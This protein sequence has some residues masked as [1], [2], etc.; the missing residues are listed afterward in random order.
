MFIQGGDFLGLANAWD[1]PCITS[2]TL[3]SS[4]QTMAACWSGCLRRWQNW[5]KKKKKK[6][7][8]MK[9]VTYPQNT[10]PFQRGTRQSSLWTASMHLVICCFFEFCQHN[11]DSKLVDACPCGGEQ[12]KT[13]NPVNK[14]GIWKEIKRENR[15]PKVLVIGLLSHYKPI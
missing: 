11:V 9:L 13:Q 3:P 15:F 6:K 1:R 2:Q 14:N 10:Q 5:Q 8:P 7:K 12:E 4:S